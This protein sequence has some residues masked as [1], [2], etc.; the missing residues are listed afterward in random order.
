MKKLL[1]TA[2]LFAISIGLFAQD[3]YLKNVAATQEFS[4]EVAQLFV[5]NKISEAFGKMTPY[6]PLPQNEI[7]SLEETTIKYL[8]L[9]DLRFGSTIDAIKVKNETIANIAIRETYIVRYK[10]SAIRLIFTYYKNEDGW[11]INAFKWDDSFTE[12]FK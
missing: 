10:N 12:E 6:W 8:N 4:E 9:L 11:I 1:I 7:S 2:F 5:E 3:Q